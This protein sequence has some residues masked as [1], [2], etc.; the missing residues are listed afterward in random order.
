MWECV[1]LYFVC[2]THSGSLERVKLWNASLFITKIETYVIDGSMKSSNHLIAV[3]MAKYYI[4]HCIAKPFGGCPKKPV[5][6]LFIVKSGVHVWLFLM[7]SSHYNMTSYMRLYWLPVR[8]L[9]RDFVEQ[10][11]VSLKKSNPEFPILI[12]ECSGVQARVWARYGESSRQCFTRW[13][14]LNWQI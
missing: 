6:K 5:R 9:F 3:A 2:T 10:H 14:W 4:Q 7:C 13:P 1:L 12:R 11:Y 8:V